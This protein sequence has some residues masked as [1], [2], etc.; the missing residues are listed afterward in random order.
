MHIPT[1]GQ[2]A[3]VGMAL[4]AA[5]A[6]AAPVAEPAGLIQVRLFSIAEFFYMKRNAL[7][8]GLLL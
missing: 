6:L 7:R 4:F 2:V 5:T 3:T 8:T 1:F